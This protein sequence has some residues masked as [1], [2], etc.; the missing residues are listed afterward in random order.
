MARLVRGEEVAP[1]EIYF[2]CAVRLRTSSPA[3]DWVNRTLFVGRGERYPDRVVI[4][5]FSMG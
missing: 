5:L 3:W 1:S 4:H 2:R